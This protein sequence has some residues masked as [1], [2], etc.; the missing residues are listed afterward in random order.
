MSR[1]K[2][3]CS[4]YGKDQLEVFGGAVDAVAE[5]EKDCKEMIDTVPAS[6]QMMLVRV[7]LGV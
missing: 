6:M 3:Y 5:E 4:V 2:V 7:S 1:G